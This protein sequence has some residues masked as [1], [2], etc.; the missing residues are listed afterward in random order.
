[1]TTQ[2]DQQTLKAIKRYRAMKVGRLVTRYYYYAKKDDREALYNLIGDELLSLGG[3]Y[4]KFLQSLVLQSSNLM[5]YWKNP[6]RLSVFEDLTNEPLDIEQVLIANLGPK[7]AT[8]LENIGLEPFAA[9]SFGQVYSAHLA[10]KPVIIKVLRPQIKELLKFDLRLLRYFWKVSSRYIASKE[11]LNFSNS[12]EDYAQQTL[13][14]TDYA[15]EA[16]FADEQ[17][18]IYADHPTLKIPKTYLGY[19]T[20][21]II[22]QGIHW[23]YFSRLSDQTPS[24]GCQRRKIH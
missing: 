22:V 19:C 4:I 12:F 9:G 5:K 1:M 6:K 13:N 18:K 7:K 3:V 24:T 21:Q 11:S 17:Y 8:K 23:R 2:S 10:G 20:D 14:E 15:A 16:Q